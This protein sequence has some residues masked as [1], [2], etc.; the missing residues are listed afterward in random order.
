MH[1]VNRKLILGVNYIQGKAG[2][3]HKDV[4]LILVRRVL[5]LGI[6]KLDQEVGKE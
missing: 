6:P 2:L 3:C 4:G 5:V 1:S